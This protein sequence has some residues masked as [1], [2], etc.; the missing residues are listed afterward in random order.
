MRDT[1]GFYAA[2]GQ[3]SRRYG[4]RN[5]GIYPS[6]PFHEHSN[7]ND[8]GSSREV[9][10]LS[11]QFVA[12]NPLKCSLQVTKWQARP[13]PLSGKRGCFACLV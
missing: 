10:Q 11:A 1:G 3:S 12:A 4:L 9:P 8:S 2:G 5:G 13:G 6:L 7:G